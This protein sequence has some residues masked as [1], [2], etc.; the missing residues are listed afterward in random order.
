MPFA[1]VW[2]GAAFD[3][4]AASLPVG[5]TKNPSISATAHPPCDAGLL[6]SQPP[7]ETGGT[8]PESPHGP[9]SLS[10]N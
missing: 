5:E 3:P 2:N 10:Q 8:E 7:P 9:A 6:E 1:I 4:A